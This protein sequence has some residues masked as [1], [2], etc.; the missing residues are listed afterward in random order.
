ME[1][2]LTGYKL[3]FKSWIAAIGW[4]SMIP[5]DCVGVVSGLIRARMA[6]IGP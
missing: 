5:S 2:A 3:A 4:V 1:M 6:L